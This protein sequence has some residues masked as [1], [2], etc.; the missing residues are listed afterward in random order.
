LPGRHRLRII[1]AIHPNG[2]GIFI[3]VR[4]WNKSR[5]ESKVIDAREWEGVFDLSEERGVACSGGFGG[6]KDVGCVFGV[7]VFG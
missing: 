2:H 6:E 5:F 1:D 3:S 7:A 4:S